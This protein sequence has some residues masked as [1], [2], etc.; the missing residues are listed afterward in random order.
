[1]WSRIRCDVERWMDEGSLRAMFCLH[2]TGPL[3]SATSRCHH[4]LLLCLINLAAW[5]TLAKLICVY[6]KDYIAIR[7]L[8]LSVWRP[9][10]LYRVYTLK[11]HFIRDP[12]PFTIEASLWIRIRLE[13]LSDLSGIG[14]GMVIRAGLAGVNISKTANLGE[15]SRWEFT[16]NYVIKEK[17]P[18]KENPMAV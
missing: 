1:M 17:H 11:G 3:T 15:F 7:L 18:P 4:I 14:P 2:R 16:Q 6:M 9:A 12:C 8:S 10:L 5:A 13:K